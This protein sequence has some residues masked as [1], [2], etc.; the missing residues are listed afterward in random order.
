MINNKGFGKFETLTIIVVII[1]IIAFFLY[2]T[3][4]VSDDRKI[5][6]IRES[7]TSFGRTMINNSTSFRN[8]NNIYL[9]EAIDEGSVK[10]IK[11]PFGGFCDGSESRFYRDSRGNSKINFRCGEYLIEDVRVDDASSATMYKVGNWSANKPRS[12]NVEEKV[13]YNC[14]SNGSE[15][16]PNY[17]EDLYLVYKINR[18]YSSDYYSI[19]N[20][21]ECSVVKKTF[22]RTK[23]AVNFDKK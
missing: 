17:M 21:T 20:I 2:Q 4:E 11:S 12:S 14:S 16:Y 18:D 23:E 7:A 9:D 5:K 6:L 22:Y 1:C 8:Q 10:K 13:L 3:L 19:D 15:L